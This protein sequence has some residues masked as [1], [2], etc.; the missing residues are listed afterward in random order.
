M[1]PDF[2]LVAD[3]AD[4]H[5]SGKLWISG[6]GITHIAGESLPITL[7]HI[8]VV[9]RLLVQEGDDSRAHAVQIRLRAPDDSILVEL[10]RGEIAAGMLAG[11][12]HPGEEHAV[13]MVGGFGGL[14]FE[15]FGLYA[16]ELLINDALA[17]RKPLAVVQRTT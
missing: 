8:A 12:G 16:V 7:P 4:T 13:V 5:P 10:P 6:G 11:H 14:R 1:R 17:L 3:S 15:T 2:L 9:A